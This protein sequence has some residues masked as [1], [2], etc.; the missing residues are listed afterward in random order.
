MLHGWRWMVVGVVA[1]A[2]LTMNGV[3][4]GADATRGKA[5]YEAN[6]C[7]ACHGPNG[8]G[9]AGPALKGAAFLERYGSVDKMTTIIRNGGGGM[10]GFADR[11]SRE[12]MD[13]L[14][15]YI[16]SLSQAEKGAEEKGDTTMYGPFTFEQLYGLGV[17]VLGL[18]LLIFF[19]I[20]LNGPLKVRTQRPR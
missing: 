6:A 9:G 2:F 5:V 19:G 4:L 16:L 3:A 17:M 20:M 11:I 1:A 14:I 8:A 7:S 15:G 13:D 10:P 18:L 12:E